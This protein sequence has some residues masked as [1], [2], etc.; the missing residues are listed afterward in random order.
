MN[1]TTDDVAVLLILPREELVFSTSTRA[2]RVAEGSERKLNARYRGAVAIDREGQISEIDGIKV[3]GYWG[4]GLLRKALSVV[5]GVRKIAV[6]FGGA[7]RMELAEFRERAAQF[8]RWDAETGDP[9]LQ[10]SEPLEDV[11]T[12]LDEISD[13]AQIFDII[14][15]PEPRDCLDV[16]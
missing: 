7:R 10:Y 15:V 14:G 4:D 9:L 13:S 3:L 12:K 8:V 1:A 2:F 5:F 16:L 6:Q 11:L